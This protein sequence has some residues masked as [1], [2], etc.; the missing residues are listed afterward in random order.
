MNKRAIHESTRFLEMEADELKQF[1]LSRY[2]AIKELEEK[3]R[4]DE[5]VAKL[6]ENLRSVVDERYTNPKKLYKAQLKAAR[7]VAKV[8]GI[9]FNP[10]K[11]LLNDD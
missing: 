5:E 7:A 2:E 6:A 9:D 10:P 3:K 4:K 1:L 11:D 8:R